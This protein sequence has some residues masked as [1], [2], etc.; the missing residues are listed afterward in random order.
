M[1]NR[2]FFLIFI[3]LYT[4][5]ILHIEIKRINNGQ[6]RKKNTPYSH[7]LTIAKCFE[8]IFSI[9]LR[10]PPTFMAI[11]L[12]MFQIDISLHGVLSLC[13]GCNVIIIQREVLILMQI[14]LMI[15]INSNTIVA[16][17]SSII[18]MLGLNSGTWLEFSC[19]SIL[20][21]LK[22]Y[23]RTAYI[24][25]TFLKDFNNLSTKNHK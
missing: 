7:V 17:Y 8:I 9:C 2:F 14:K 10:I 24:V 19:R 11:S 25:F 5:G 3:T 6:Y 18:C 16:I 21:M 13:E 23:T 12:S 20:K 22:S 4:H 15:F 1:S